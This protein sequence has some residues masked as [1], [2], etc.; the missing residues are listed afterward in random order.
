MLRTFNC[1]IGFVIVADARRAE[2]IAKA[3]VD[4]GEHVHRLGEVVAA[5]GAPA[6]TF[7]GSL[8]LGA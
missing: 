7:T 3:F 8:D 2:L 5:P 6:V 1:G 4:A